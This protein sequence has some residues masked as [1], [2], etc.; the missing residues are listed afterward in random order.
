MEGKYGEK[1]RRGKEG[2]GGEREGKIA[3]LNNAKKQDRAGSQRESPADISIQNEKSRRSA[4]RPVCQS[5][6][7]RWSHPPSERGCLV[8]EVLRQDYEGRG[9]FAIT[10]RTFY[11]SALPSGT[12][13]GFGRAGRCRAGEFL[14]ELG[15]VRSQPMTMGKRHSSG[16]ERMTDRRGGAFLHA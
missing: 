6:L 12:I 3:N 5:I 16:T 14:P 7:E 4:C 13:I 2:G 15:S 8:T 11:D 9:L 10:C 1:G